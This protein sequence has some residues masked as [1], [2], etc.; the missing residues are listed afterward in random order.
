MRDRERQSQRFAIRPMSTIDSVGRTPVSVAIDDRAID[1][2]AGEPSHPHVP[3]SKTVIYELHV[4][5]F[6]ANAP[7][8]PKEL[9]GTYAGLAHPAT[10]PYLQ[11]LASPPSNCY[12][13]KPNN[14]NS[15]CR[16][17]DAPTTGILHTRIFR[18]RSL[19][20]HQTLT[21]SRR[22]RSTARGHRHGARI[23]RGR[24]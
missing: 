17:E 16:K 20:C 4:K 7:W 24:L 14:R 2:H 1:K 8:L 22:G 3:W 13:S 18:P 11:D 12:R 19:I 5:G 21:R 9:R 10:L 23:A 15:S 6:T